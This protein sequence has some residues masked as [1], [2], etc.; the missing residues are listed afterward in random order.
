MDL[1][2]YVSPDDVHHFFF[3]SLT[4]DVVF[5]PMCHS[6]GMLLRARIDMFRRKSTYVSLPRPKARSRFVSL[7]TSPRSSWCSQVQSGFDLCYFTQDSSMGSGYVIHRSSHDLIF[8]S[9][10]KYPIICKMLIRSLVC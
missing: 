5:F 6:C 10:S 1:T 8:E 4:L 3:Y 7:F 9:S 2:K